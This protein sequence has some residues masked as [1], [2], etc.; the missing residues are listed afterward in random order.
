MALILDTN[1]LIEAGE[2][3]VGDADELVAISTVSLAELHYGALAVSDPDQR[4]VRQRILTTVERTFTALP[5]DAR[6]AAEWGRLFAAVKARGGKPGKRQLDLGIA[7][8][9][10][11]H[12]ATLI[13]YNI[14]DFMIVEDLVDVRLP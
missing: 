3:P 7:A 13:T 11:A 9:A 2:Q 8:T 5:V 10:V 4:A 12:G 1:V 6:V 14:K